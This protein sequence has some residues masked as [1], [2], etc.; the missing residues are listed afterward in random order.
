MKWIFLLIAIFGEVIATSALKMSEGFTKLIPSVIVVVGYGITFYF[1]SLTLKEMSVGIAYAM[2]AGVGTVL[3]VLSSYFL[4]KQSF[5]LPAIIGVVLIIFG[6]L[7]I[8]I[9]SKSIS[10]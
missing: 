4:F 9:F 8:N 5:D 1:L 2:W 7:V 3:I 10:H 6:V